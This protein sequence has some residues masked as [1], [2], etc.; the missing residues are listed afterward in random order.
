MAENSITEKTTQ[1]RKIFQNLENIYLQKLSAY[2]VKQQNLMHE[3]DKY[4]NR[5]NT[6]ARNKPYVGQNVFVNKYEPEFLSEV[7]MDLTKQISRSACIKG[8]SFG[9]GDNNR[10]PKSCDSMWAR[11]GCRGEFT[12]CGK[13][14]SCSSD[15]FK[16]ATC[17]PG[18]PGTPTQIL[19]PPP[20]EIGKVGYIVDQGSELNKIKE[21][22]ANMLQYSSTF[23]NPEENTVYNYVENVPVGIMNTTLEQCKQKCID[24][25][26]D[27]IGTTWTKPNALKM[28][29]DNYWPS[30]LPSDG[31]VLTPTPLGPYKDKQNRAMN[32]GPG[33]TNSGSGSRVY[34]KES[35][36]TAC[37]DYPYFGLQHYSSTT[38]GSQCFCGNDP[39]QYNKY[40]AASCGQLG[41]G[42]CNYVYKNPPPNTVTTTGTCY[43]SDSIDYKT[44][45]SSKKPAPDR[46]TTYRLPKVI[47]NNSC[48]LIL[49]RFQ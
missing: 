8:T 41:G 11:A 12:L 10:A 31:K 42:W 37:K 15:G 27:C 33:S 45:L 14:V 25:G 6:S 26:P 40:G 4:I 20:L 49:S 28:T 36:S 32:Y 5:I 48:N 19:K 35:C 1:D 16:L 23:S 24:K 21:Y 7:P 34:T 3:Y 2:T 38:K 39:P 43:L 44:L 9:S 30:K 46:L 47:N 18:T 29:T 22:P 17:S 13:P